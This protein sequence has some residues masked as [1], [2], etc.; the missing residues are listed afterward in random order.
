MI[1]FMELIPRW[2]NNI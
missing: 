1:T 2:R